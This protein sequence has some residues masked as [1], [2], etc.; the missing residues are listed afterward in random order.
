MCSIDRPQ[1]VL[2]LVRG[3]PCTLVEVMHFVGTAVREPTALR[4]RIHPDRGP[5]GSQ[6]SENAAH[7]LGCGDHARSL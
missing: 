3:T 2:Y 4:L 1:L 7:R 6:A 5:R